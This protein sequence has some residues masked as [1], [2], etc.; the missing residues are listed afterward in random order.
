MTNVGHLQLNNTPVPI[1]HEYAD[2]WLAY[3]EGRWRRVHMQVN[4]TYIVYLGLKITIYIEG[5]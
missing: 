4:R 5:V 1:R 3:Y 2:L